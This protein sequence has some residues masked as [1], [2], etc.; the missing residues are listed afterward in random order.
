[1]RRVFILLLIVAA[2][3]VVVAPFLTGGECTAEFDAVADRLEHA[4]PK[5]LT[6]P[7]AKAFLKDAGMA[8]EALTPERCSSWH[9]RDFDVECPGGM[10]LV[11]QVPISNRV[12]RYY[13]DQ[14]VLFRL[15][16]NGR[17]QLVRI[18]TDMKP[19]LI[20]HLPWGSDLFLAK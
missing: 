18:Q 9:P 15:S 2:L 19:Y 11:G 4:R 1:M 13:R 20:L 16:Y 8:Y 17:Q 3:A 5:L 12:C 10:L 6:L 14:N 7:Q